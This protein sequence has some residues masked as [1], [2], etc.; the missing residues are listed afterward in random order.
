MNRDNSTS[1]IK[2]E[3]IQ[4]AHDLSFNSGERQIAGRYEDIRADHRFRYE[5]AE[6]LIPTG[7]FGIDAF[8]GNGY[9]AWLLGK[10]R[11]VLALDGSKEA[12]AFA[13]EHFS[14]ARVHFAHA[15]WPFELP[16]E[17]FDFIVSLESVEHVPDGSN[18]FAALAAALKPGGV[19]VYSTPNEDLL[20]LTATG[21]HFHHRHYT[22]AEA[23]DLASAEGLEFIGFAGQNTYNMTPEGT[24][25]G[26][27]TEAEMALRDGV[28]GQFNIFA[29]RK[30]MPKIQDGWLKKV[31]LKAFG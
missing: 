26:L 16:R 17:A 27:V 14:G 13:T 18:F 29:C 8:C 23:K 25:G 28:A 19:L 2:R 15:Y 11:Q 22:T 6:R 5:W 4:V 12:V 1:S 31:L 3:R 24:Q 30:P 7:G 20:P 10:E 9:G 21:N